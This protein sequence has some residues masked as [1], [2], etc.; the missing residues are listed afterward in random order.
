LEAQSRRDHP[1]RARRQDGVRAPDATMRIWP[2]LAN[3]EHL[4]PGY[5]IEM[6]GA[7]EDRKRQR[8]DLCGFRSS[9]SSC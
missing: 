7:I 9:A 2:Q 1:V 8:V 5:R 6:G 4:P 3:R